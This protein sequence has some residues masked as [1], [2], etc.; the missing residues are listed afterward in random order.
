MRTSSA[1]IQL[2]KQLEGCKLVAYQCSAGV[3]TIG[4]GFTKGVKKGDTMTQ[5]QADAR[6]LAELVE[7]EDAVWDATGGS[8]LR[9]PC[10]FPVAG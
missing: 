4:Y 10:T 7:Y 8:G 3:W 2:L 6:L 5:Q 9:R 1:G